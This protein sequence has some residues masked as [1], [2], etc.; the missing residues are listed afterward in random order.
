[1]QESPD[2]SAWGHIPVPFHSHSSEEVPAGGASWPGPLFAPHELC[3]CSLHD[4]IVQPATP[5][6]AADKHV[7]LCKCDADLEGLQHGAALQV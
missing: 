6:A 3:T 2:V 4:V 5:I 7:K 1:M